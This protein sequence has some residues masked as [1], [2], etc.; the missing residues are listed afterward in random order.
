MF[1][2]TTPVHLDPL[3]IRA[4]IERLIALEPNFMYLT[5]HGPMQS[6]AANVRL[7]LA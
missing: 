2:T 3:A 5:H 1:V 7:L 4:S 6:T